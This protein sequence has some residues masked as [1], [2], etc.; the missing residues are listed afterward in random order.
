MEKY[1]KSCGRVFKDSDFKL[2]P[3]CGNKLS[4]RTGRQ[5]IPRK[6]RHQ[7]FQRDNYRCRE[8]GATNKQTRLH[9][10]HIVPVA[11]GG[12]NDLSNLQTLCEAC[13]RAKY[14]DE[15]VGGKINNY[16]SDKHHNY[17]H[18]GK[19]I[20]KQKLI[21]EQQRLKHYKRL[22]NIQ[23]T[24]NCPKC[25]KEILKNAIRCVYCNYYYYG[26]PP[27][28]KV[29]E[30][31]KLNQKINNQNDLKRTKRLKNIQGTKNCPK[32]GKEILKNAIRCKH[33]NYYFSKNSNQNKIGFTPLNMKKCPNCGVV[34]NINAKKCGNC[35]Y[36]F[37]D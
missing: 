5:P 26:N 4:T 15:W 8:C 21:D 2:C 3:Y 36:K 19:S 12:T 32:C 33:C 22:K 27:I 6:L 1:C 11:K 37:N 29:D 25:G 9:V 16:S 23:G 10:D 30:F 35:T 14:T 28:D 34:N 7:V 17:I 20:K 24:K 18:K 31:K 13:N